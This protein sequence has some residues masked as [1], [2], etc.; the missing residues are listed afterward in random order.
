M[1]YIPHPFDFT[2]RFDGWPSKSDSTVY[3]PSKRFITDGYIYMVFLYTVYLSV[4]P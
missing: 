1:Q 2:F 3:Y 4:G